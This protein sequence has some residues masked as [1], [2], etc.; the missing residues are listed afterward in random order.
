MRRLMLNARRVVVCIHDNIS[1]L[2][3]RTL[4]QH[5][6]NVDKKK[7]P[8]FTRYR[9]FF[10]RCSLEGFGFGGFY[11]GGA[12]TLRRRKFIHDHWREWWWT[13]MICF[14]I[15]IGNDMISWKFVDLGTPSGNKGYQKLQL[16]NNRKF[17]QSLKL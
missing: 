9:F 14:P 2:F 10:S 1:M 16:I 5:V 15:W 7:K 17:Y 13:V 8:I 6:A 3:L 12:W 11:K 4:I